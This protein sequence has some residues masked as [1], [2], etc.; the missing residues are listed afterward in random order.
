[1]GS[2]FFIIINVCNAD[3]TNMNGCKGRHYNNTRNN[4]DIHNLM[5]IIMTVKYRL[6]LFTVRINNNCFKDYNHPLRMCSLILK[7]HYIYCSYTE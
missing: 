3:D 7:L 4:Y 6:Y 1:M 5:L 2:V